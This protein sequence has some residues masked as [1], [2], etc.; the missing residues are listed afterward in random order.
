MADKNG[1]KARPGAA[2]AKDLRALHR[3][4][5]ARPKPRL[6]IERILAEERKDR[7]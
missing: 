1:T 5:T 6:T 7:V 4:M 2:W 3:S